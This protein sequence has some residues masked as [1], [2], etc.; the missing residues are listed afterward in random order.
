M[1]TKLF[2]ILNEYLL[3]FPLEAKR[4]SNFHFFLQEHQEEEITNWNNF[5]AH[6]VAGG[7]VYAKEDNEFLVVYY[8]NLKMYLYPGVI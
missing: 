6:I 1:K 5:I 4:Q 7:F 3:R 2:N 8:R